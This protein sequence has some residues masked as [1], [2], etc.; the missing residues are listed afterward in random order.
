[1]TAPTPANSGQ[2]AG[3]RRSPPGPLTAVLVLLLVAFA[4]G[5][6][7]VAMDRL[8]LL[9]H[10]F[11]GPGF[12]HEHG[13]GRARGEFRARF[14]R[15]VG[16]SPEQQTLIDSIMDRQGRE[17]RAVRGQVQPKLDSII[18]RTRRALDSVLTPEQR[19]KAEEIRRKHPRPPGPPP[20][21]FGPG[22]PPGGAP[23]EGPPPC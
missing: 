13:P 18:T 23:P 12:G 16:L 21:M 9:P 17:L 8:L 6:A 7:G 4:G 1:M 22:S 2:S 15:E 11:R 19:K 20:E 14:A 3:S 10:M 5:L